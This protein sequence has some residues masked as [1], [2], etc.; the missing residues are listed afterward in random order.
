MTGQWKRAWKSVP[1]VSGTLLMLALA[2]PWYVLAEN[3]TPGF[4]DY[5]IVGEHWKRFVIKGW[6]GDLYGNAHSETPG[7]I[8]VYW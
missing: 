3:K 7:T 4:L 8:W 5:F 2:L 1:W 6:Q